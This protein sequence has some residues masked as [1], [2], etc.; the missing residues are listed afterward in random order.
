MLIIGLTAAG[1]TIASTVGVEALA[2]YTLM[3]SKEN[4]TT[5]GRNQN[6]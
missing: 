5:Q 2:V 6:R 1:L 3:H 4:K